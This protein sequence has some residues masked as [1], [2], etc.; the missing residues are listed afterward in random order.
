MASL[1]LLAT[2]GLTISKHYCGNRLVEVAVDHIPGNCCD[3]ANC[4]HNE[5][6]HFQLTD[7]FS[8]FNDFDEV[9]INVYEIVQFFISDVE[10]A[11]YFEVID[12]ILNHSPNLPPG[13]YSSQLSFLQTFRC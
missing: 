3:D 8:L 12:P 6:A 10:D 2:S 5:T 9:Q 13:Y 4:C 7:Y 1:L 11:R